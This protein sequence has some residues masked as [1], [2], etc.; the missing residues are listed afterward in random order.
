MLDRFTAA[1]L[2]AV[3]DGALPL[4]D[5]KAVGDLFLVPMDTEGR[6]F[7][8]HRLLQAV[9]LRRLEQDEPGEV[10]AL[11]RRAAAWLT[12]DGQPGEA[13]THAL[14]A[15]DTETAAGLIGAVYPFFLN[16]GQRPKVVS[17]LQGLGEA[18]IAAHAPAAV[19]AAWTA[20]LGGERAAVGYYLAAAERAGY[21][22]PLPDGTHALESAVSLVRAMFG[23]EGF[24]SMAE[25]AATAARWETDATSPWHAMAHLTLGNVHYLYGE[26]HAAV[27][28]LEAGFSAQAAIPLIRIGASALLAL[29]HHDLGHP[30]QAEQLV[31]VADQLV[32]DHALH[33]SPQAAL[34]LAARGAIAAGRGEFVNAGELLAAA[35]VLRQSVPGISP[36]PDLLILVLHARVCLA[37]GDPKTANQLLD[38]AEALVRRLPDSRGPH[39]ERL[40]ELRRQSRSVARRPDPA[41]P[42]SAAEIALLQ[43][44]PTRLTLG[45]IARERS[46][47][48]NTVKT[49]AGAVYR[50][51]G[52]DGR[53]QA[54]EIARRQGLIP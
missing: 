30:E 14:A 13:I 24:A 27:S 26:P 18:A 34:V 44:F 50:K 23:F 49:Q 3:T 37:D 19:A 38:D 54:V 22:G 35:H 43:L 8:H 53:D 17:W 33:R 11:H 16:T 46:V 6:W 51:L 12:E 25:A 29:C 10:A 20:A 48:I 5:P 31:G 40:A 45:E 42:L 1:L 41:D 21:D 36:W 2:Q 52:A 39:L 47:S 9:L 4:T 15:G 28:Y 7:R 32:Q